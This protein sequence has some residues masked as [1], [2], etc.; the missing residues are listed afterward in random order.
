MTRFLQ[1]FARDIFPFKGGR[2]LIR[3]LKLYMA[4][5]MWLE[6]QAETGV[7][8]APKSRQKGEKK[9]EIERERERDSSP[10]KLS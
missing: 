5:A 7:L 10:F 6:T 3:M 2:C 8:L 1:T 4:L 9:R